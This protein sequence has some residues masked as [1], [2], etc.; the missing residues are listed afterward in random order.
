[1]P[2][3]SERLKARAKAFTEAADYLLLAS[4]SAETAVES[5][6][7]EAV[8]WKLSK[9]YDRLNELSKERAK[10]EH[11]LEHRRPSLVKKEED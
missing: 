10:K 11:G 5:E 8:A 2:T 3:S 1:V 4:E 9:E 6:E 7:Y